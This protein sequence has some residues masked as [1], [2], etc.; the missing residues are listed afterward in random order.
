MQTDE[1]TFFQN[2]CED[3]NEQFLVGQ[4]IIGTISFFMPKYHY[5][6]KV[7]HHVPSKIPWNKKGGEISIIRD[8]TCLEKCGHVGL[9]K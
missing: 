8:V 6:K 9:Q 4:I 2:V 5:S 3:K 1:M 7:W